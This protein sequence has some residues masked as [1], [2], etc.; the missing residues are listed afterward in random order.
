MGTERSLAPEAIRAGQCAA[1]CPGA[2]GRAF[3]PTLVPVTA[4]SAAAYQ[5]EEICEGAG[6]ERPLRN[7]PSSAG[8]SDF[9]AAKQAFYMRDSN[10]TFTAVVFLVFVFV[11]VFSYLQQEVPL[12]YLLL[13]T[14]EIPVQR[15]FSRS[16]RSMR[17]DRSGLVGGRGF[18]GRTQRNPV[19][20]S[21]V[22][23]DR[24][25]ETPR[26][27]FCP[28]L[29]LRDVVWGAAHSCPGRAPPGAAIGWRGCVRG[30][31]TPGCSGRGRNQT[32][33]GRDRDERSA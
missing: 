21:P 26:A 2:P 12:G 25:S 31:V 6:R 32:T 22:G 16:D 4:I 29:S 14:L 24:A 7:F 23:A 18:G 9:R 13:S 17:S 1:D 28:C 5:T 33:Q 30:P 11:F 10:S 3:D 19:D 8:I 20:W 27:L 15:D